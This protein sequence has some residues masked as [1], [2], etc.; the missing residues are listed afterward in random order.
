MSSGFYGSAASIIF[1]W[2]S[3]SGYLMEIFIHTYTGTVEEK[4]LDE[5]ELKVVQITHI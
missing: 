1:S 5:K 4:E 2:R 3:S